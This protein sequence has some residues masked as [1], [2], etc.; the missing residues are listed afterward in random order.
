MAHHTQG[1]V[2]Q[3]PFIM[4]TTIDKI[5]GCIIGSALGDTIGLYTE[6]LSKAH[7]ANAYPEKSF[8]LIEPRTEPYPDAHR[9]E[10]EPCGW[11]DDTD[12]A[13]LII[14]SYLYIQSNKTNANLGQEFA[15]RLQIWVSRGLPALDRPA[16]DVGILVGR[17]AN[18]HRFLND[19]F[20]CA[21]DCWTDSSRKSAPN[22]SLMRT[23]PIG[24][25]G[26]NLTEE[27]TW[28]LSVQVG[29]TTHVDPRCVVSCCISV[30]VIRQLLRGQIQTEKDMNAAIE[31][32][33]DWVRQQPDLM[34]PGQSTGLTE[35]QIRQHLG[36]QEFEK[37]VYAETLK[38]LQLDDQFKI[39][40]VYKCLGSAI[41]LLRLAIRRT[42]GAS[43]AVCMMER[44]QLFEKLMVE[45]IM[46]GGDADTNGAAA[47][48]LLGAH[49]G[50][51]NLPAHWKLGLAHNEWLMA[52]TERLAIAAGAID[53]SLHRIK[54][55]AAD[56]GSK[57]TKKT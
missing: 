9:L 36:R 10:F 39:G 41:L 11:T 7:S 19:P 12:Q 15:A 56:G 52:K 38:E 30:G 53:G 34:N 5:Y 40:Y 37:H 33:Y 3:H 46:E 27:Q 48:A 8:T 54:D 4:A 25:I 13:L 1:L 21:V 22:G 55:E 47:G 31:R 16:Y 18:S 57:T 24:V 28:R 20:K 51:A 23:H 50:Y 45:L 6:F 49:L 43:V 29:R 42:S 14:L 2:A 35:A 26:V 44:A 17:V 32:A